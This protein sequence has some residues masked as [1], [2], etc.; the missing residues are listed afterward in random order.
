MFQLF[1]SA[2]STT[3]ILILAGNAPIEPQ[4][5]GKYESYISRNCVSP[6]QHI[7]LLT[8]AKIQFGFS[9]GCH[10][11]RCERTFV[12]ASREIAIA[13][14][15]HQGHSILIGSKLEWYFLG[16]FSYYAVVFVCLS[17]SWG[18]VRI[19]DGQ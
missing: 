15:I 5:I 19:N 1:D 8:P 12:G 18:I 2:K 17:G 10:I 7:L 6:K 4:N 14:K 11:Q 3:F 13:S 9:V 16:F